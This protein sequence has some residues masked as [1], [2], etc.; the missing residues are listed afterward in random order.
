MRGGGQGGEDEVEEERRMKGVG[1]WG[2]GGQRELT[3]EREDVGVQRGLAML[4]GSC[5]SPSISVINHLKH[6][7]KNLSVSGSTRW[8]RREGRLS[9]RNAARADFFFFFFSQ[10]RSNSEVPS[11]SVKRKLLLNLTFQMS[12]GE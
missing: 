10:T 11:V 3:A 9:Q 7:N 5:S 6:L 8:R 12:E 1:G 4:T 2:G